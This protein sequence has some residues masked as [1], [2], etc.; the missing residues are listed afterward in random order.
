MDDGEEENG[1]GKKETGADDV[2]RDCAV[3]LQPCEMERDDVVD[4]KEAETSEVEEISEQD[5]RGDDGDVRVK[6][7][8]IDVAGDERDEAHGDGAA[9]SVAAGSDE[10]AEVWREHEAELVVAERLAERDGECARY[11]SGDALEW[12]IDI[13]VKDMG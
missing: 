4:D 2:V 1:G 6:A 3:M 7:K 11:V 5:R 10:H 8:A 13:D 12:E 9:D